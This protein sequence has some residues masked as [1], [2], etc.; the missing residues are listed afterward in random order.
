MTDNPFLKRLEKKSKQSKAY[1]YSKKQEK[2]IAKDYGGYN[3]SG[4]GSGKK[5]GDA[6]VPNVLRVEA[7][8]TSKKS[9]SITRDMIDKIENA[10]VGSNE[11]PI[12][13]IDFLK[14]LGNKDT[15][16]ILPKW[17]FEELFD[18]I[19]NKTS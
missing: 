4:S 18:A 13:E 11:L 14:E 12:I 7:K 1:W 10:A 9:F 5:K 19:K 3:I 6:V 8:S 15:L 2:N 16:V 17:A